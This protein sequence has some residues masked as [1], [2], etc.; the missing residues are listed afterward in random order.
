MHIAVFIHR[1]LVPLVEDVQT[2][3]VATGI[4]HS[5]AIGNKG[6][7]A[8]GLTLAGTSLLFVNSHFAAHQVR[9]RCPI[10]RAQSAAQLCRALRVYVYVCVYLHIY[11]NVWYFL[12]MLLRL[13]MKTFV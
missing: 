2:D 9:V 1:D 7:V 6:G 8:V 11:E 3:S 10:M 12:R 4:A 5:R 13:G